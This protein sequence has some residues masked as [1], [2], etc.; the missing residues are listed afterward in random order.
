M[1]NQPGIL[2]VDDDQAVGMMLDMMLRE[3]GCHVW[4]ANN[5]RDGL[6]TYKKQHAGVTLVLMDVRMP[7]LDGPQTLAEMRKVDPQVRCV[8]MSGDTGDY[9]EESLRQ[10]SSG[11]LRKPF[12]L[13]EV[14]QVLRQHVGVSRTER[15]GRPRQPLIQEV[16]VYRTDSSTA[17]HGTLLNRS[18]SGVCLAIDQRVETGVILEVCPPADEARKACAHIEVKY[19]SPE[20][21]RWR[22]GGEFK[23]PLPSGF[24]TFLG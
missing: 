14:D 19:C 7:I 22:V 11:F 3:F 24:L 12:G 18:D 23:Q 17:L 13:I 9:S 6:E 10:M 8:F 21:N 1:S 20:A 5:G 15:R 16:L 2:V 4:L